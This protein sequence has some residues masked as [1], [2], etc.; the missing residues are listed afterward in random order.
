[1][2]AGTAVPCPDPDDV[3]ALYRVL[4][5]QSDGCARHLAA[6]TVVR[7]RSLP[8][9][10]ASPCRPDEA[11]LTQGG[12]GSTLITDSLKT[13]SALLCTDRC[14]EPHRLVSRD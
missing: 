13:V 2:I 4:L 14:T 3:A 1:M 9:R 8:R 10:F 11:V 7:D 12:N 5:R 6:S